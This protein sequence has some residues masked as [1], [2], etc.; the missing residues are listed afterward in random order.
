MFVAEL[1][2]LKNGHHRGCSCYGHESL[3]WSISTSNHQCTAFEIWIITSY[4]HTRYTCIQ[5]SHGPHGSP[6]HRR[7]PLRRRNTSRSAKQKPVLLKKSFDEPRL[8]SQSYHCLQVPWR[9]VTTNIE[10]NTHM[11]T[12]V[13]LRHW[14]PSTVLTSTACIDYWTSWSWCFILVKK[15]RTLQIEAV[16]VYTGQLRGSTEELQEQ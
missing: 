4:A 7:A 15:L 6:P 2:Q 9:E 1:M 13:A 14:R 16:T 3:N 10:H 11:N 8:D 5:P 12:N